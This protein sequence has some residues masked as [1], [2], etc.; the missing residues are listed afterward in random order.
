[1]LQ[2]RALIPHQTCDEVI[3]A[4]EADPATANLVVL[5]GVALR[6]QGDLV[7]FDVARENINAIIAKLRALGV[8]TSG[9]IALLDRVTVLSDAAEAASIAAA[10]HPADA[11]VWDEI[12]DQAKED[13]QLSWSFLSFLVLATLISSI[14]RYLD[15]PILIIGAMV[16]GPEFAP[17]AAICLAIARRR[18][19]LFR[20]AII[21][22]LGGFAIAAVI[23]WLLW[24]LA[25]AAGLVDPVAA[26]TGPATGFIV[27]PDAWSFV[28]ALLAGCAGVLSLT[29]AKS[30]A[31]VGVFISITTV[32]AL[33][34]M[35]L[36]VAVGAWDEAWASLVQLAVNVAGI[37]VAGTATL[38]AQQLASQTPRKERRPNL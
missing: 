31:L 16:V 9:S 7:L 38:V 5:R 26:T 22:L 30:S 28:I 35:G 14:G 21:T 24:A 2:I 27:Q 3:K 34:A 18:G 23:T 8:D 29:T 6:G 32:P 4:I 1:M 33:G 25:N 20:P 37:I 15:Q 12:E 36:T 17:I 11:V 10:G 13:A 19:A